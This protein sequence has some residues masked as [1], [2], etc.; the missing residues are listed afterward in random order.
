MWIS[1][2]DRLPDSGGNMI[3][4]LCLPLL[5]VKKKHQISEK[6]KKRLSKQMKNIRRN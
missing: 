6:E 1:A 4:Q 5:G 3:A 2:K